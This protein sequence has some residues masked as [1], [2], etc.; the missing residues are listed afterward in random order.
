MLRLVQ[1]VADWVMTSPST[2]DFL[3]STLETVHFSLATSSL[4]HI[5]GPDSPRR[6]DGRERWLAHLRLLRTTARREGSAPRRRSHRSRGHRG[7]PLALG[8]TGG[9]TTKKT[10]TIRSTLGRA[11]DALGTPDDFHLNA[12]AWSA[13]TVLAIGL[14]ETCYA[15]RADN[16]DVGPLTEAPEGSSITSAALVGEGEFL[17]FGLRA[18]GVELWDVA[19]QKRLRV[20]AGHQAQVASLSWN[21]HVLSS[22]CHDGSVWHHDVRVGKHKVAELLG[23][24]GEVCGLTWRGDGALLAS[25]GNDNV[26]NIWDARLVQDEEGARGV[27]KWTKR[28][29]TAAIKVRIPF[30]SYLECW[31]MPVTGPRVVPVI[32]RTARVRWRHT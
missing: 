25:G 8:F 12:L 20:M 28:S 17:S 7:R 27:A 23:H 6:R 32:P 9:T 10:C 29:H 22:G 31:L 2:F 18:G 24:A 3:T 11:L 30:L 5:A 26:V 4:G 19:R 16:D 13:Q 21:G 1:R 14:C 15:W